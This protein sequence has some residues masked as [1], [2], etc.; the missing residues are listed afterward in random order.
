MNRLC[1]L[2]LLLAPTLASTPGMAQ[3]MA[4]APGG[5]LRFLDKVTGRVQD[6]SL[7]RGQSVRLGRLTVQLDECRYPRDNPAA[8][9]QAHMTVMDT[10]AAQPMFAGWMLASS[11]ALSAMDHPRYDIWVLSCESGFVA[12]EVTEPVEDP[13]APLEEINEG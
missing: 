2:A 7:S 1:I 4:S 3:E 11:P 13:D 6:L 9:A 8:D 10:A 5:T 12:P